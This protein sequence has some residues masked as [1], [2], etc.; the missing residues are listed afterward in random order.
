MRVNVAFA[1]DTPRLEAERMLTG[2]QIRAARAM[3]RWSAH[4]L[5]NRCGLSYAAVQRAESVDEMPNMQTRNLAAIKATFDAAGILFL[6]PGDVRSG[7]HG[8]RMK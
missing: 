4:D 3:L 6:D 8:V 5:A 7:G 2:A 1:P